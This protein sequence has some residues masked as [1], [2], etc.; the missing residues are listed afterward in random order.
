MNFRI[1][2]WWNGI[3]WVQVHMKEWTGTTWTLSPRAKVFDPSTS[4]WTLVP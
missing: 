2:L 4:A 1:L 3:N